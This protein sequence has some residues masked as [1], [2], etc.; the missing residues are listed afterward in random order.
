MNALV[1]LIVKRKLCK[2]IS[3]CRKKKTNSNV[4]IEKEQDI[5]LT[6]FHSANV[7]V[8]N[9]FCCQRNKLQFLL[10]IRVFKKS[11]LTDL[12]IAQYVHFINFIYLSSGNFIFISVNI[13]I[14]SIYGK[15]VC[16]VQKRVQC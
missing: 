2:K 6:N 10:L 11:V 9:Y 14:I 12:K 1:T 15:L 4:Q 16:F 3:A 5:L 8:P 7:N 13:L